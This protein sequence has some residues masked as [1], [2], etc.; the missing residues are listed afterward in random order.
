MKKLQMV[1]VLFFLCAGRLFSQNGVIRELYGTVELKHAGTTVFVSAR[2]NDLV[3]PDTVIT[4][5]ITT[6]IKSIA[7]VEIGSSV[8]TVRPLTRL[9]LVELR[10]TAGTETINVNLQTGRVQVN[11]KPPAETRTSMSVRGPVAT[12]SV[13]GTRFEFDTRSLSVYEGVVALKGS[14]GG[15]ILVSAGSTSQIT[16]DDRTVNP[17]E[18]NAAELLPPPPAGSNSRVYRT[19]PASAVTIGT[20][21]T[22]TTLGFTID[23]I[24]N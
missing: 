15:V 24:Q 23:L 18:T 4:T 19:S 16:E 20:T 11:V 21:A 17:I 22:G 12:A 14:R 10:S 2:V 1:Q 5:G 3:S 9:T 8:I 6:G 7:L 13:R